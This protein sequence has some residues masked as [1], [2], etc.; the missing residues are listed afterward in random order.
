MYA[1]QRGPVEAEF[2]A[3]AKAARARLWGA[4]TKP[5]LVWV[6]PEP[7]PEPQEVKP[8]INEILRQLKRDRRK[9]KQAT[10]LAQYQEKLTAIGKPLVRIDAGEPS[11]ASIV[12][13][14]AIRHNVPAAVL[15]GSSRFRRIVL[16]RRDAIMEV[17]WLRPDLSIAEVG[18]RMGRDH[19]TVLHAMHQ[20]GFENRAALY[21][22]RKAG[23]P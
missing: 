11:V 8:T 22:A 17:L 9:Q 23:Q 10:R 6:M 12:E 2:Y 18:R 3:T 4:V 19:T 5:K 13:A 15:F 20:A 14:V 16:P 7:K 1:V 21:A